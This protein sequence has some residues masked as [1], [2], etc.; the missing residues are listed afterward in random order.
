[1][2]PRA[3]DW[4]LATLIGLLAGSGAVT[5]TSGSTSAT[6]L[7]V[8]HGTAGF[9]LLV[10]VVVKLRR[11]GPRVLAV[12]HWERRT[13]GG[14][15][16][17]LL[18]GMALLSGWIWSN[19]GD[20]VLLGLNLLNWH[21][22]LGFALSL[23]VVMHAM[24]R[25]KPLRQPD[26]VNR[27][28]FLLFAG[29]AATA[30]M[31]WRLQRPSAAVLGWRGARRRW[32][33]SYEQG[34]LQGNAFPSSSWVADRPRSLDTATYRLQV[35]GLVTRPLSLPATLLQGGDEMEATLDCT[36]GFYSTQHWHGM[37]LARLLQLAQPLP[38]ATH[39]RIISC[40]GY[41]WS[42]PLAEAGTLLLAVGVGNEAL[43]HLH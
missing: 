34:S 21:I 37:T 12:R 17:T 10:I 1:M 23:A 40:T 8:L 19:G 31:A 28:Q 20:R 43:G 3:T 6:W 41:R 18:V 13:A 26:I 38:G 16:T 4:L 27:R 29:S 30:G 14:L 11:V 15:V 9:L 22:A 39:V 5:L 42:F 32:T 2:T 36:G 33:G 7:F 24:L 25:A 35:R